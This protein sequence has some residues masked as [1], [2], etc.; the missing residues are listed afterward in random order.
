MDLIR[1]LTYG[2][3]GKGTYLLGVFGHRPAALLFIRLNWHLGFLLNFY[4]FNEDSSVLTTFVSF[5]ISDIHSMINNTPG[6]L[7]KFHVVNS[8]YRKVYRPK[9]VVWYVHY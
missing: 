3:A 5:T 9:H 6:S 2:L 7:R 8:L 1:E 4:K